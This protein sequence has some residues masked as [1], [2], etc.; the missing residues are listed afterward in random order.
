MRQIVR[1]FLLVTVILLSAHLID[2]PRGSAQDANF[3]P[4]RAVILSQGWNLVGWTGEAVVDV[5][6]ATA[7]IAGAFDALFTYDA[8]A[9]DF[10]AFSPPGPAFLNTLN[11]VVAGDGVWIFATRDAVWR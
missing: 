10:R 9:R 5:V 3:V 6:D 11:T 2:A 8:A 1:P 7:S 4:E